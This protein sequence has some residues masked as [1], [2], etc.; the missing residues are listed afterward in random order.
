[1]Q[2]Q[3]WQSLLLFIAFVMM[4]LFSF[5]SLG[6][7]TTSEY[8]FDFTALGF[9]VMGEYPEGAKPEGISTWYLFAVS[10]VTALL[11]LIAIFSYN[12][13]KLQRTLCLIECLLLACVIIIC[14]SLAYYVVDG[15]VVVWS[16]MI[17]APMLSLIAV[18][19]AYN[20]ICADHKT[21]ESIGRIR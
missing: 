13:Y 7:I 17:C 2:I 3:R 19:M 6:T 8:S 15:G 10:I 9:N 1:M 18:I 5:L 12:K 11:P 4:G 20:R 21:I 14:A 16:T